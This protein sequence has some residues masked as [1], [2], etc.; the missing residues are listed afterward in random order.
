VLTLG[1]QAADQGRGAADGGELR[2][3]FRRISWQIGAINS[4]LRDQP[5]EVFSAAIKS[6]REAL[7]AHLDGASVRLPGAMWLVRS[8]PA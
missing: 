2:R 1:G 6:L 3:A 7:T 8:A 4:W 5:A